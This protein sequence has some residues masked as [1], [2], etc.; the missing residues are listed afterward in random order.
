MRAASYVWCY[1]IPATAYTA[2][3]G[4]VLHVYAMYLESDSDTSHPEHDTSYLSISRYGIH[5]LIQHLGSWTSQILDIQIL[6]ISICRSGSGD[7]EGLGSGSG[8][9]DPSGP[10]GYPENTPFRGQFYSTLGP[11]DG[12]NTLCTTPKVGHLGSLLDPRSL[13][14][15]VLSPSSWVSYI[16]LRARA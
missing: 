6:D 9:P 14:P 16:Y 7:L 15:R 3:H 13:A 8:G 1:C 4:Y 2:V 5:D 11:L 10:S 12:P